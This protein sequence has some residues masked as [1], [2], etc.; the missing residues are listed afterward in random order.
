M[1]CSSVD[2]PEPDGPM[3][4]VYAPRV[5]LDVDIVE[6]ANLGVARRRRSSSRAPRGRQPP[7]WGE[8]SWSRAPSSWS[9]DGAHYGRSSPASLSGGSL[10]LVRVSARESVRPAG[11]A[12]PH[13][14]DTSRPTHR[15]TESSRLKRTPKIFDRV[16]R[17]AATR[18]R[19]D[20]TCT[21]RRTARTPARA[22]NRESRSS[23]HDRA[24][25]EQA[26]ERLVEERR[27]KRRRTA[28]SRPGGA[29]GR[30]RVPTAAC[31]GRPNSSWLK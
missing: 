1:Q 3:I 12:E 18:R 14:P 20:R 11:P 29:R 28:R 13:E 8:L 26:P 22:R 15:T 2:L 27:M 6:R 17:R 21:S 23:Q 31:V 16:G 10:I 7:W 19:C 5:E 24:E 30:S 25:D 4:A 9:L